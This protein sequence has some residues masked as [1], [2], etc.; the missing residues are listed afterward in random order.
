MCLVK[1]ENVTSAILALANTHNK[2][3]NGRQ[4]KVS[5]SKRTL[6]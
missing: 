3:L 5:F 2:E 1:F 6:E 4:L